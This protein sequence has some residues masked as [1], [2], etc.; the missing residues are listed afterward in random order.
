ACGDG[1]RDADEDCDTYA[2]G[3]VDTAVALGVCG[4][5]LPMHGGGSLSGLLQGGQIRCTASCRFDLSECS[6]P[7]N[8]PLDTTIRPGADDQFEA[9]AIG[10]SAD[11]K[12]LAERKA[13][14]TFAEILDGTG[15]A[16]PPLVADTD[17]DGLPNKLDFSRKGASSHGLYLYAQIVNRLY[18]PPLAPGKQPLDFTGL[19]TEDWLFTFAMDGGEFQGGVPGEL[20]VV[21]TV[22]FTLGYDR[23]TR[24]RTRELTHM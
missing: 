16:G 22:Q 20:V 2:N 15:D 4:D 18:D 5:S 17:G 8:L 11:N 19:N 7:L 12:V 21:K 3:V 13:L 14:F 6:P 23:V 1:V 9:A 10:D 24:A